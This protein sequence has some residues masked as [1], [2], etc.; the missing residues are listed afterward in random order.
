MKK[1]VLALMSFV[2]MAA[3]VPAGALASIAPAA[4]YDGTGTE[5]DPWHIG[6]EGAEP[7]V[8][9]YITGKTLY[10][11]GKGEMAT[12]ISGGVSGSPWYTMRSEITKVVVEE[13][14]TTISD[15]AFRGEGNL[16][17]VTLPTTIESIGSLAFYYCSSLKE[18]VFYAN[19]KSIASQ[20]FDGCTSLKTIT[21]FHTDADEISIAMT[22][23]HSE[24]TVVTQVYIPYTYKNVNQTI[25]NYDWTESRSDNASLRRANYDSYYSDEE[26]SAQA[27]YMTLMKSTASVKASKVKKKAKKLTFKVKYASTALKAKAVGK[28]AKK[29]LTVKASG[30]NKVVVKVKKGAAKGTYKVKV[31]AK[32]T[33]AYKASIAK[34]ITIVIK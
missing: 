14:V 5:D 7:S 12:M 25:W 13:G 10:I 16:A 21:F 8:Y 32:A 34:Y 11:C 28:K 15:E 26:V 17:S 24:T 4:T 19:L 6:V 2:L 29:A 27:Q 33:S 20:A 31:W 3:L 9:A 1:F 30:K 23:F 18:I 22:A